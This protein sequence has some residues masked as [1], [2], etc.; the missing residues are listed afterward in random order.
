MGSSGG[1]KKPKSKFVVRE[2]RRKGMLKETVNSLVM[3]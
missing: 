3:K 2:K 1:A